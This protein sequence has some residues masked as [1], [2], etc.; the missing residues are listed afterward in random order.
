MDSGSIVYMHTDVLHQTE[1]VDILTKPETSCTSNVPPYK[2]KANEVYLFQTGADDWKCDQ[3]LWINNGTKSVTIGNDVLK[4]HFYKIRLPGTTDKTNG[5]KRPV[6]SLQFKKTAYSLKSNKSLILVHY[7]GDETVYVPVG[8]GNSKKSDPPEYTRTAPSV[9][10][11]IE[12]DI[13]SGEKTA[14]DVYRESIS[15]GSVSGEHQGVLNARNVKQVENLVRKVNEEERLSKDDIYNLLLLAYHMDGFI[16][17]VTV[18]P[19]L[20][21][22]IALPEMISIVNQ[23][24]D[25]NTEDD[26][27]FVFFYDTTFKCGDFFVSPLVFRNI[28]FED[29]PIMPVAFLIHSRK[30]E[31]THARFFEFVASSFPKI[32]KTSVPFVTDREIGL[33]N[34]IRKN[35][36]SCDVLMCW[37]HLIKDL[38]FNLQQMGA[39]QSNTA[40]YVSH[41]KDLLRSDSE[42]EYMTLKDE[43]I[44]KWSK[45][46]VVYFEKM[47]KDILTH[48]G[49]WVIDKYQNLYD[50]YSGITNNACESMNAVIKRLNKYRE[51]PVDC[52]VLS[53]FYLQNYYINEVQRGLAGIG[54]YTLRTKFNHASIPKDEINVPKQLV[55]P[56]DIVKHVM[57]EIDNV[58][59]TCSKDHVSVVKVI[60][61]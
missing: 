29:R 42:A 38:K 58:R 44:R 11:K 30:K 21:S 48:S 8:H 25:V 3:Y 52:F 46:V 17:E 14:M 1:I 56:A 40:L 59:D 15:N 54:N 18:F 53:M 7:E 2:P 31:K 55:K 4:K 50:P 37:N 49:K 6:G 39:D 32:N 5:R 27:P 60:F 51:L 28:I 13:R 61:S 16:H 57:S 26:V 12:Q 43:L 45:P 24:L 33:V 10:R 23:L 35:F 47:E 41:L 19:D 22:I 34:A 20:S 9:L 36:P